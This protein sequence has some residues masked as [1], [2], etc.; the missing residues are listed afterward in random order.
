MQSNRPIISDELREAAEYVYEKFLS[1]PYDNNLAQNRKDKKDHKDY[2]DGKLSK[3]LNLGKETNIFRPNHGIA[4]T[5]RV[6]NYIPFVIEFFLKHGKAEHPFTQQLV[7][8]SEQDLH[9]FQRNLQMAA[10]FSIVGRQDETGF[11]TKANNDEEDILNKKIYRGYREASAKAFDVYLKNIKPSL[12]ENEADINTWTSVVLVMGNTPFMMNQVP[13]K[14]GDIFP[15]PKRDPTAADAILHIAHCMDLFRCT[16][17]ADTGRHQPFAILNELMN[18]EHLDYKQDYIKLL[19]YAAKVIQQTGNSLIS[20]MDDTGVIQLTDK[21][22]KN[23]KKIFCT[24]NTNVGFCLDAI[25]KV[26]CPDFSL[27]FVEKEKSV[28]PEE[29]TRLTPEYIEKLRVQIRKDA[30]IIKPKDHFY[31]KSVRAD[32]KNFFFSF[33]SELVNP[34]EIRLEKRKGPKAPIQVKGAGS[35]RRSEDVP[36]ALKHLPLKQA[37]YTP[38]E[39]ENYTKAQSTSVSFEK[40]YSPVFGH[41]ARDILIGFIFEEEDV[42]LTDYLS[43]YDQG[44]VDRPGDFYNVSAAGNYAAQTVGK[45]LFNKDELEKFK[46]ALASRDSKDKN[47]Q[48]IAKLALKHNEALVRLKWGK[49]T[50]VF[51]HTDTLE[52]RLLAKQYSDS[53]SAALYK[54]GKCSAD[55]RVPICFYTPDQPDLLFKEYTQAEYELDCVLAQ[56]IYLD[57]KQKMFAEKNYEFLL[58]LSPNGIKQVLMNETIDGLPLSLTLLSQGRG[59]IFK[60]LMEKSGLTLEAVLKEMLLARKDDLK[61]ISSILHSAIF[62][63]N[64]ELANYIKNTIDLSQLKGRLDPSS[65]SPLLAAIE[66][67]NIQWTKE[68][69]TFSWINPEAVNA[70]KE[71]ILHLALKYNRD[72]NILPL[73]INTNTVNAVSGKGKTPLYIAAQHGNE[74]A[75][76]LLL[77]AGADPNQAIGNGETPLFIATHNAHPK[78]VAQ[79]LKKGANANLGKKSESPLHVATFLGHTEIVAELL[80]AGANPVSTFK[81]DSDATPLHV[82]AYN[83][84]IEELK[85]LLK[86]SNI[87]EL[88]VF[89]KDGTTPLYLAADRGHIEAVKL[90]LEAGAIPNYIGSSGNQQIPLQ[91]AMSQ[92]DEAHRNIATLIRVST[93]NFLSAKRELT[94]LRDSLSQRGGRDLNFQGIGGTRHLASIARGAGEPGENASL[95]K[96]LVTAGAKVNATCTTAWELDVTPLFVAVK[97]RNIEVLKL[98]LEHGANPNFTCEKG[99]P[100]DLAIRNRDIEIVR[101]M[102]M[103][104]VKAGANLDKNSEDRNAIPLYIAAERGHTEALKLLLESGTKP[105]LSWEGA[106]PLCIAAQN[107]HVEAVKLLLTAG[108]NPELASKEETPLFIAAQNGQTVVVELL[109]KNGAK[110]NT[111]SNDGATP[112]YMAAQNGHAETIKLLLAGGAKPHLALNDGATPLYIAAQMGHAQAVKLLLKAGANP[113]SAYKDT[114][115][116]YIAAKKGHIDVVRELLEKDTPRSACSFSVGQIKELA[117][118]KP[119]I[120]T[121]SIDNF[122]QEKIKSQSSWSFSFSIFNNIDDRQKI[123]ITPQE[124]AQLAGHSNIVELFKNH[125]KKQEDKLTPEECKQKFLIQYLSFLKNDMLGSS[126][127]PEHPFLTDILKHAADHDNRS[128]KILVSL[129]WMDADG[130][131]TE[132]API[133]V[134]KC[135]PPNK[136]KN[137]HNIK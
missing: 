95:I 92:N 24:C 135:Y 74:E 19:Q 105:D 110:P 28:L 126:G 94:S 130:N 17:L 106:T 31:F 4:H 137:T 71:N 2:F 15:N 32:F 37:H 136:N 108:A 41:D 83:G 82:A 132:Y 21:K 30:D 18:T 117:K 58:G 34:K 90:L 63:E 129:D 69:L 5:L 75:V 10:L 68:L 77:D 104:S 91:A 70:D 121:E 49:S 116:L 99:R 56:Q 128:R 93:S 45:R 13:E 29:K 125:V 38:Q 86:K 53:F 14:Y 27:P 102:L 88:N 122:I 107:G 50:K 62:S 89:K 52:S 76:K 3:D 60:F 39:K 120:K 11:G 96:F 66:K 1:K 20:L 26:N 133:A 9:H 8:L 54:A 112:L 97:Y 44:T 100:L 79:L 6:M 23:Y 57:N 81:A 127:L 59:H 114:T 12:I 101:L 42:L 48:D 67:D 61:L 85:L 118:N 51:I 78:V 98:L 46:E 119:N 115:P 64:M 65:P 111:T 40:F 80:N 73:L 36:E 113:E 72:I 33:I 87:N 22:T 35:V 16:N 109:L 123:E 131:L 103:L 7:S 55:Y 25:S 47:D 124:I 84:K 43:V 134:C